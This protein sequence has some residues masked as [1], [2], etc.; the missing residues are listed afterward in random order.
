M[1]VNVD[2]IDAAP[3]P[4]DSRA[5]SEKTRLKPT[6]CMHSHRKKETGGSRTQENARSARLG[7]VGDL[8]LHRR[9]QPR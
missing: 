9:A 4:S 1:I 5:A 2:N 6:P 3:R 8:M 7:L